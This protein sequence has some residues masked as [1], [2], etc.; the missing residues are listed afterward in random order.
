VDLA[1]FQHSPC[2]DPISHLVHVAGRDQV[3]DVW[4][5]GERLVSG[6]VLAALD[7]AELTACARMWQDRLQ[8][9]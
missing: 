1:A 2:Y 7:A 3:T 6:G 8:A 5:A 9:R 4:I